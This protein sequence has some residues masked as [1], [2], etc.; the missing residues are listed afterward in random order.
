MLK[1][2][3]V[4]RGMERKHLDPKGYHS[5][6][7]VHNQQVGLSVCALM[8]NCKLEVVKEKLGPVATLFIIFRRIQCYKLEGW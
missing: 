2:H 8:K 4:Q 6:G 5:F 3:K 1:Y 7:C